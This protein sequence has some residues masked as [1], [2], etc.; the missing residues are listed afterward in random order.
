MCWVSNVLDLLDDYHR[1]AE[2]ADIHVLVL[3]LLRRSCTPSPL[4][5]GTRR[6]FVRSGKPYSRIGQYPEAVQ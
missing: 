1:D 3:L 2:D 5:L 6:R 4:D